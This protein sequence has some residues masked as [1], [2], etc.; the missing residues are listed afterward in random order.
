[1]PEIVIPEDDSTLFTL[2]NSERIP[3][4]QDRQLGTLLPSW[5]RCIA[6]TKYHPVGSC[7]LKAAGTEL[8]PLCALPHYGHARV[9]PHIKSETMVRLMLETLKNS[10]EP[11]YLVDA[12]TKYLRGVKGHLVHSKK[13]AREAAENG[14]PAPTNTFVP[15]PPVFQPNNYPPQNHLYNRPANGHQPYPA[16]YHTQYAQPAF[17]RFTPVNTAS[18]MN[19]NMF[20]SNRPVRPDHPV[21]L[22]HHQRE[23]SSDDDV[24][25]RLLAA[26]QERR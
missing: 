7:P 2:I 18:T 24:E 21:P 26:F 9:C 16:P 19:G 15:P 3:A 10:S 23:P 17:H 6:C 12:A 13:R 8:C 4:Y 22:V 1:V 14:A 5:P 11:R 20:P 25:E